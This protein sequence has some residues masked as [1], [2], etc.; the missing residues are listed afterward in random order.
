MQVIVLEVDVLEVRRDATGE[1]QWIFGYGQW[2]DGI[3]GYADLRATHLLAQRDELIRGHVLVILQAD[4]HAQ[5]LD[6]RPDR[7][8]TP[9]DLGQ[10]TRPGALHRTPVATQ[11]RADGGT[12]GV[13]ADRRRNWE[14]RAQLALV[15]DAAVEDDKQPS[16]APR[17][18]PRPAPY[19]LVPAA[20]RRAGTDAAET[21]LCRQAHQPV[22]IQRP[23]TGAWR[24]RSGET[25]QVAEAVG[26]QPDWES[27]G[28]LRVCARRHTWP[29]TE[30]AAAS[31][32]VTAGTSATSTQ[33]RSAADCRTAS[34]T[35][36]V[37]IPS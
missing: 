20:P 26:G 7:V 12:D 11:D 10:V 36:C 32:A 6:E 37:R 23:G 22:R 16:P 33:R 8:Q 25:A 27:P 34:T 4:G 29:S 14:Q 5:I 15:D 35:A 18:G 19:H 13:G 31:G 21:P 3:E 30:R 17:R 28:V 9:L 2:V 24:P 1:Y